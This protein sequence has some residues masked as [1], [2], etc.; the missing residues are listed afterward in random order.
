MQSTSFR[1]ISALITLLLLAGFVTVILLVLRT[2][3]TTPFGAQTSL[4]LSASPTQAISASL[5]SRPENNAA[6]PVTQRRVEAGGFAFTTLS[7][8]TLDLTATSATLTHEAGVIFLLRGG[9]PAQ[10]SSVQASDLDEIFDSFVAFYGSQDNFQSRNKAPMVV[11]GANGRVVDLVSATDA[12]GFTGRIVMAQP[13]VGQLFLLVG[14]SPVATWEQ[15]ARQAFDVLLGSVRF[16]P[17]PGPSAQTTLLGQQPITA[18]ATLSLSRSTAERAV[19]RS[20]LLPTPMATTPQPTIQPEADIALLT[21]SRKQSNWRVYSN[22]NEVNDLLVLNTRIW[23]ATGGGVGA[24]SRS[25]NAFVKFTTLDGL[26][27]NRTTHVVHCPL[28]GFGLMFGSA[29]GLQ[30]FDQQRGTWK[31]LNSANSEMHFDDVAA[32][33]CSQV[34]GFLIVGYAQ[35]GLDIFDEKSESWTAI[36]QRRGLAQNTVKALTV[37]GDRAEIWVSSGTEISVLRDGGVISYDRT[38]APLEEHP[39][40]LLVS[41]DQGKVWLAAG[42]KVYRIDDEQWTIYSAAYVLASPFPTGEITALR[43]VDDGAVWIGSDKGELCLFE[44]T[45]VTCQP[46]VTPEEASTQSGITALALDDL[47]RL[48]VATARA[49]VRM[50]DENAWRSYAASDEP[51]RSNRVRAVAQDAAGFLW[52]A[53][54]AGLYQLNPANDRVIQF[55][56]SD[57]SVYPME[58]IETLFPTADGLW[59]GGQGAAYFD[60]THWVTYTTADGLASDRVQAIAVDAQERVWFGTAAGLSIWNGDSFFTLTRADRLPSDHILSLL[61]DEEVMWIGSDAGLLRFEGNQ[62]QIYTTATTALAGNR[63]SALARVAKDVLLVGTD[64]G[65][66]RW[67]A[68]ELSL[69]EE[70]RGDAVTA[71]ALANEDTIWLGTD[72]QGVR[73]FDGEQWTPPPL[74]VDPPA[75]QIRAIVVDRQGATWVAAVEGGLIRY[76]P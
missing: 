62:F 5:A 8:Y 13:A 16:F 9:T 1:L 31:V 35:H 46:F 67:E 55:F 70:T 65:L 49:G 30:I 44:P 18:T 38:N 43:L 72:G 40:D 73:Y 59:V 25:N 27:V 10:L 41:D 23:A 24:W 12:A 17:L 75:P 52:L 50:V 42:D 34:Y 58:A 37:I 7:T 74:A 57:N 21:P 69:I 2:A 68:N 20:V 36:D 51:I 14:I 66:S 29:Q 3:P 63:I 39:V 47:G 11:D 53:T 54:D 48:Y 15:N 71:I 22:S 45:V 61:P 60:G 32:L 33:Y 26:G 28:P 4:R 76:V 19:T 64:Q 6:T 56:T